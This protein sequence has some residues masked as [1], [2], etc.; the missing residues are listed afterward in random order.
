[1][2]ARFTKLVLVAF[3]SA[4]V[5]TSCQDKKEKAPISDAVVHT[6]I[7]EGMQFNPAELTINSGDE[8]E[9]INR[10]IVVHDVSEDPG[11][12]WG[13]GALEVGETYR[14]KPIKDIDY[15][16]SIHPTMKGK[17]KMK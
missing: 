4:T 1:M 17:I 7:I 10:D 11:K 3:L 16:C 8:V 12:T 15:F 6:V 5:L 2:T 14:M 9:W 13:S